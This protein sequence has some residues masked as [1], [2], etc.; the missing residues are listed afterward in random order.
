[1]KAITSRILLA[2]YLVLVGLTGVF[3]IN[4]GSAGIIVPI[5]ALVAGILMLLGK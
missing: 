5:L 4:L 1:M 2:I 3:H